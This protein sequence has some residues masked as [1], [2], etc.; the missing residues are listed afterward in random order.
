MVALLAAGAAV[1]LAAGAA[2]GEPQVI[3]TYNT[4]DIV[5][6]VLGTGATW[7]A[8]ENPVVLE[9]DSATRKRLIDVGTPTLTA[10]LLLA[11]GRPMRVAARLSRGDTAGRY[12][13]V[14]TLPRP[15]DWSV[16][17]TWTGTAQS[18]TATFVVPARATR[19]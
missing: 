15:G 11:G 7:T 13:G 14:I 10:V 17:V 6:T 9:F 3:R 2:T 4:Q 18:G 19:P 5:I 16:T 1:L 12:V 8:G